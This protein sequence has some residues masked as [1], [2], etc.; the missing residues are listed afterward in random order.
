VTRAAGL[1]LRYRRLL[2][3]YPEPFR[4]EREDEMLAVLMAG[5]RPGQRWPSLKETADVLRS[6]IRMR[7]QHAM[8]GLRAGLSNQ[9]RS[10]ALALFSAVVPVFLVVVAILQVA[11]PYQLPPPH[12]VLRLILHNRTYLGGPSMLRS[13]F[14]DVASGA[15]VIVAALALLGRRWLTLAAMAASVLFWAGYWATGRFG[16]SG[17]PDALQLLA[18][19]GYLLGAAALLASPGPGRGRQLMTWRVWAVL[20]PAAGFA[21]V[22]TLLLT[23]VSPV[24]RFEAPQPTGYLAASLALGGLTAVLA[25]VLRLNGT[26]TLLLSG[27]FYPYVMEVALSRAFRTGPGQTDLLRLPTPGHLAVLFVPPLLLVCATILT[28]ITARRARAVTAPGQEA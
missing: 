27:L 6:A 13:A 7:A 24:L 17:V 28:A 25:V 16:I 22:S 3:A 18:A 11:V 14:F 23:A 8:T 21:Q 9:R 4:R 19:S 10:D 1:A 12:G 15:L 26:F 2:A 5:A 20:L